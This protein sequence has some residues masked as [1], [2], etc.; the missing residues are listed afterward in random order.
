MDIETMTKRQLV[1]SF[2]YFTGF[3]GPGR[4]IDADIGSNGEERQHERIAR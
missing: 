4:G 2:L 3:F 1:M